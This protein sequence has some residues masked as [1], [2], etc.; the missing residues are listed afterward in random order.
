MF[1]PKDFQ[2]CCDDLCRGSRR[3]FEIDE[4]MM[5]RCECGGLVAVD[6]SDNE[7]CTCDPYDYDD[8]E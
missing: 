7:Q 5:E 6:G 3:C 2:P 8:E 1:C 4:A